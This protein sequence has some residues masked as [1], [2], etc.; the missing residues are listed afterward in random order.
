MEWYLKKLDLAIFDCG[1]QK[2]SDKVLVGNFLGSVYEKVSMETC[3][4]PILK[5]SSLGITG[6]V[7][8]MTSH[9][10]IR[11]FPSGRS[12]YL[13]LSSCGSYEADDV[14]SYA[15]SVFGAKSYERFLTKY[16]IP[17]GPIQVLLHDSH[18]RTKSFRPIVSE[19]YV[20]ISVPLRE[21]TKDKPEEII[22]Q[23]SL[24]RESSGSAGFY[25]FQPQG[26]TGII[27]TPNILQFGHSWPECDEF[28]N[29]DVWRLNSKEM[30]Y[31]S[32]YVV[33]DSDSILLFIKKMYPNTWRVKAQ[34]PHFRFG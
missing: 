6:A 5:E 27:V 2:L 10:A 26:E 16:T 13:V 7:G 17:D 19:R 3:V 34:I 18:N 12:A 20:E 4:K 15:R 23:L 31:Q 9:L 8:L 29:F 32:Y 28:W 24:P 14:T 11:T 25:H 1:E 30:I 21:F 33:A 22:E